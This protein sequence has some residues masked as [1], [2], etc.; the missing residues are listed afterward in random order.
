MGQTRTG[1]GKER[2]KK[3][4][5]RG[6]RSRLGGGKR[7]RVASTHQSI[8]Y[9]NGHGWEES[10]PSGQRGVPNTQR[11]H[12]QGPE[13][14]HVVETGHRQS[15]DVVIVQGAKEESE[16]SIL[17]ICRKSVPQYFTV[18]VKEAAVSYSA[19]VM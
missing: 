2:N 19:F 14:W 17:Q 11:C 6:G 5:D 8:C 4:D 13:L 9:T 12:L 7:E 18:T 16:H 10:F 3:C 15:A 1:G